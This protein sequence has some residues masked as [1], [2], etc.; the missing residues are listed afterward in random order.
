MSNYTPEVINAQIT[1]LESILAKQAIEQAAHD[2][3]FTGGRALAHFKDMQR[4]S[5]IGY[6]TSAQVAFD[7]LVNEYINE[8]HHISS[9]GEFL[10]IDFRDGSLVTIKTGSWVEHGFYCQMQDRRC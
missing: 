6:T 2:L 4:N 1:T 7:C 9:T 10:T 8:V 5:I 3:K